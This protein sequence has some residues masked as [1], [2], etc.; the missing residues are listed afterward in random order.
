MVCRRQRGWTSLLHVIF[1][2]SQWVLA[3]A[4]VQRRRPVSAPPSPAAGFKAGGSG[5]S[6][7][8]CRV[9]EGGGVGCESR[10]MIISAARQTRMVPWGH[11]STC[12][13]GSKVGG[14]EHISSP[15]AR[16]RLITFSGETESGVAAG[17]RGAVA[18]VKS[19]TLPPSAEVMF[20]AIPIALSSFV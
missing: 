8:L 12:S 3:L 2:S 7:R 10:Q 11:E 13:D 9:L 19:P 4:W 15:R 1:D 16:I 5:S 20:Q 6:S 14:S 17:Q 18:S